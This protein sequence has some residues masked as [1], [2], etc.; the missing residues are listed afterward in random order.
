MLNDPK[1]DCNERI[2]AVDDQEFNLIP[3]K[4][5]LKCKYEI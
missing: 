4:A 1:C 3:V 5:L 2:L